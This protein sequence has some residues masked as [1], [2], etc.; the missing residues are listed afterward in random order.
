MLGVGFI[1]PQM[2]PN[3]S[4]KHLHQSEVQTMNI[5]FKHI[6]ISCC[7]LS[8]CM[9]VYQSK[10]MYVKSHTHLP[11]CLTVLSAC[12]TPLLLLL[13]LLLF[14]LCSPLPH[15]LKGPVVPPG[16][17]KEQ[18][19]RRPLSSSSSSARGRSLPVLQRAQ[20]RDL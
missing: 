11:S 15:P 19:Q 14:L 9:H 2:I 16:C 17:S 18:Q 7:A 8:A 5:K 4:F 13:L 3:Y 6:I 20:R 10:H 12:F 1:F